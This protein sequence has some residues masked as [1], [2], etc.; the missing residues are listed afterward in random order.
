MIFKPE[1]AALVV[2]GEKTVTRRLCSD[3]PRSPW[4]F[5]RCAYQRGKV[6][7]VNP[8][9]GVVRIG[10]A[11]V[12]HV[13]RM[14]LGHLSLSEARAEGFAS[15]REFR[16]AFAGINGEYDPELMVWRVEFVAL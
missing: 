7:T 12:T 1:L 8:G 16:E 11:R 9:R 14:P 13:R 5:E 3:N 15:S 2:A 6:F 10:E 4:W